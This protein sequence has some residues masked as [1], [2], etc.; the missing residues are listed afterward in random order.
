ML[1]DNTRL[2]REKLDR[3]QMILANRT[4]R[5]YNVRKLIEPI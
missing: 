2:Y 5:I 1:E 3:R 4:T